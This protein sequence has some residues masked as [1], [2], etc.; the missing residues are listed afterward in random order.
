MKLNSNSNLADYEKAILNTRGMPRSLRRKALK[1][2][3]DKA[4]KHQRQIKRGK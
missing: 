3:K 1:Y 4:K 2:I